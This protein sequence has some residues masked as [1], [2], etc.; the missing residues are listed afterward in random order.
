MQSQYEQF[1]R[2]K[3]PQ[4]GATNDIRLFEGGNEEGQAR[5]HKCSRIEPGT[6]YKSAAERIAAVT[7]R[8]GT[9]L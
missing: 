7:K 3:K 1:R 4:K 6:I 5:D 8:L 2:G 9:I